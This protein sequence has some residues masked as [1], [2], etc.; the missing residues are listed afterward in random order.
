MTNNPN[1]RHA[2]TDLVREEWH[3][4]ASSKSDELPQA[5]ADYL[6][7]DLTLPD[8]WVAEIVRNIK[9]RTR[10]TDIA[11]VA[12]LMAELDIIPTFD[13]FYEN[14]DNE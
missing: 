12:Q 9:W 6:G 3:E 10:T 5:V 8:G 7:C 14:I 11:E 4:L 2:D 1:E 13:T